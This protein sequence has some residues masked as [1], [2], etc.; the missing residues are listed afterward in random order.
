[1]NPPTQI[2]FGLSQIN[3]LKNMRLANENTMDKR[4]VMLRVD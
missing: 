4:F 1:M 2:V 3:Y